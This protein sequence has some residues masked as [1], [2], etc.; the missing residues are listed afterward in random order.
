MSL[1]SVLRRPPPHLDELHPAPWR[2][3][4]EVL[5]IGVP[6]M[7]RNSLVPVLMFL[8]GSAVLGIEFGAVLAILAAGALFLIDRR[9]G[10]AGFVPIL[11]IVFVALSATVA[12]ISRSVPGFF[13]PIAGVDLLMGSCALLSVAI[14]RPMM[15]GA[16]GDFMVLT[17]QVRA[18]ATNQWLL[19]QFTTAAGAYFLARAVLR[20]AAYVWLP[21]GWFIATTIAVE[22]VGDTLLVGVGVWRNTVWLRPAP[23]DP[24]SRTERVPR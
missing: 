7:F 16:V 11:M 5:A 23:I 24:P 2:A 14:G 17:P 3:T 18:S 12:V 9:A 19:R 21:S 4:L 15:A 6:R 1:A 20:L 10:S 8:A 22:V 13:L